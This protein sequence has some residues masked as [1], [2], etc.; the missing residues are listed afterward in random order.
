MRRHPVP[1]PTSRLLLGGPSLCYYPSAGIGCHL[2]AGQMTVAIERA[3]NTPSL[4]LLRLGSVGWKSLTGRFEYMRSR[5]QVKSDS[6]CSHH[7][8]H[9]LSRISFL[10]RCF[11]TTPFLCPSPFGLLGSA[12]D[13]SRLFRGSTIVRL[14]SRKD[15]TPELTHGTRYPL[16]L[17]V[18]L[19]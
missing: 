13:K 16:S 17:P 14:S 4:W 3:V 6:D 7:H 1:P 11:P 18:L 2:L 12:L 8:K 15:L 9:R 19:P 10:A 5:G